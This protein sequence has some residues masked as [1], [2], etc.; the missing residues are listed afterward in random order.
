[1][2]RENTMSRKTFGVLLAVGLAIFLVVPVAMAQ[3]QYAF[4]QKG[5]TPEQ[6]KKDEYD[7]HT[8]AVTQTGFDPTSLR[9]LRPSRRHSSRQGHSRALELGVRHGVQS[10]APRWVHW[11][12]RRARGQQSALQPAPWPHGGRAASR[13]KPSSRHRPSR[14]QRNRAQNSRIISGRGA[15]VSRGKVTRSSEGG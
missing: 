14:Q 11:T 1:M 2:N 8:W 15:P 7:C 5:Q 13:R 3:Q 4:P 12:A 10:W 6:Q 9:R